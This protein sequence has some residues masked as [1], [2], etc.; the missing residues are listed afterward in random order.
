MSYLN[1]A[2]RL[3]INNWYQGSEKNNDTSRSKIVIKSKQN[4]T[5]SSNHSNVNQK[6]TLL[7]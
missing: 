6:V 3:Y 4:M 7:C 2:R 1:C 5:K